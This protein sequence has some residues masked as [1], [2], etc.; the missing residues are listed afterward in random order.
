MRALLCRSDCRRCN[1]GDFIGRHGVADVY[2]VDVVC[3]NIN[4]RF[5]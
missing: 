2:I 5:R 4:A 1:A 3:N